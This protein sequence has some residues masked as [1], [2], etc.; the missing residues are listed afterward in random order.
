M[1]LLFF[2]PAIVMSGLYE[3]ARRDFADMQRL[4]WR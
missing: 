2:L 1:P 4:W 3:A